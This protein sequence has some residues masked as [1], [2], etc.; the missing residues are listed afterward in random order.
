MILSIRQQKMPVF[1]EFSYSTV[2]FFFF[3]Q[4]IPVFP[5]CVCV[6]NWNDFINTQKKIDLN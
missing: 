4:L 5:V 6:N 3:S 1:I 2:P